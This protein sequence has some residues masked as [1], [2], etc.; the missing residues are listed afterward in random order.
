[1]PLWDFALS[2]PRATINGAEVTERDIATIPAENIRVGRKEFA[3][4][5]RAAERYQESDSHDWYGAGVVTT[6]RW[7]ASAVVHRRTGSRYPAY[8]P[9]T[10]RTRSAIEELIQAEYVAAEKL[11]MRR[12]QPAWLQEQPGWIEAVCA[13][14]RWAWAGTGPAPLRVGECAAS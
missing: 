1:M 10:K 7:L 12:P 8:A 13:T 5:W 4:L 11:E 9:V 3:A 2:L 6:C 14:F